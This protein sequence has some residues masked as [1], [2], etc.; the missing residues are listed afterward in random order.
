MEPKSLFERAV[1]AS[2]WLN[3][4]EPE[5][6]DRVLLSVADAAERRSDDILAA[7]REDLARKDPSDP[8]YDRLQLTPER[9]TGI[10]A[11]MRNVAS[12][13]S[14]TALPA[15]VEAAACMPYPGR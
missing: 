10:A 13:P 15:R 12:L 2:R 7:N 11:D 14:P 6:I 3:R 1:E 9:I 5:R 8:M 4:I